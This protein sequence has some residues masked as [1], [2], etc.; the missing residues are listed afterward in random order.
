MIVTVAYYF[1]QTKFSNCTIQK[2]NEQR[3]ILENEKYV[4]VEKDGI[5]D[6]NI[7]IIEMKY[8]SFSIL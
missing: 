4:L 5:F 7:T 8:L 3:G 6:K 1:V 2:M